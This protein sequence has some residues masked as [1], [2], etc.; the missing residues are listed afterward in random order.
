MSLARLLSYAW[1]VRVARVE[2]HFG[3]LDLVWEYGRLVVNGARSN[4]SFGSLHRV[5]QEVL[6]R[7][8]STAPVPRSVLLLGFGGGSSAHILRKDRRYNGPITGVDIDPVMLQL[9]RDRFGA[10]GLPGLELVQADALDFVAVQRTTYDLV[11][12]DLFNDLDLAPG[13]DEA[14]FLRD[15]HPITAPGGHLLFNTVAYHAPSRERSER[16]GLG[17]RQLF[18]RV[19]PMRCEGQ[20]V[21]FIAGR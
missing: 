7:V 3:P 8:F 2:G 12:V 14:A 6:R 20:N 10:E 19:E 21:V 11:L 18:N 13:V 1:P 9:A 5:W 17:L 16:I 4:Q 15:L